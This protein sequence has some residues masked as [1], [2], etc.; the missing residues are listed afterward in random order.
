M[1][2]HVSLTPQFV[3][4]VRDTVD[5]VAIAEDYTRLTRRG[6]RYHGLCPLHREKTPSF[7]VDGERG[8][9]YCFGCGAGGDAIKLHMLLSGDDF[10][11]A[12]ES[13]A[14]RFGVPLPPPTAVRRGGGEAE[15]DLEAVLEAAAEWFGA[16]LEAHPEPRAYLER[17]AIPPEVSQRFGVGYAPPGWEGL[18]GALRSRFA[19]ADLEAAGLVAPSERHPGQHYDR[20]RN[21]LI[22]PIRNASARL[23]G[24][25]GRALGDEPAKYLNTRETERF[26]KGTLLYGLDQAKR[27]LRE[28]GRGFLVE[29]Y[30]DVLGA[31]AAGVEGAVASMGTSLTAEQARLLARYV[32]E[33]V[34]GYDGDRAGEEAFRR[35]LGILLAAGCGV[36]R[37]RLPE[38]S[39]PD[40]FRLDHGAE[41]LRRLVDTAPD[42]VEH[43][44]LRLVPPAASRDPREQARLSEPVVELLR[45]IPDAILRYAYGRRAAERLGVPFELLAPRLGRGDGPRAAP[46]PPAAAGPGRTPG[47]DL[48]HAALRVLLLAVDGAGGE[49]LPAGD[50]L[51]PPEV[52]WDADC[53]ALYAGLCEQAGDG[54]ATLA[55][56]R[57]RLEAAGSTLDLMARLLI[58]G[59]D[60]FGDGS[61]AQG[62]RAPR[63]REFLEQL[64]DRWHEQRSRELMQ[65]IHEAQRAGDLP[66]LERLVEEKTALSRQ[67]HGL[68]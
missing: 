23:V 37:A 65:Q 29:G 22:F 57:A 66:R 18:L 11:A 14:R 2:S 31:V 39:D 10:P 44:L 15:R 9:F 3:Q 68:A 35:A 52:F 67:V 62:S 25:G 53:R 20:F 43:E 50:E 59:P 58:E 34:V 8:L 33:V 28:S 41:A 46:S 32:D 24:F 21:R 27:A 38:G 7:T 30:F 36:R 16:Q 1:L 42:G 48:E 12:M 6:G 5:A 19:V 26:A 63:L 45:P 56:V 17:R 61:G 51:P 54:G 4:A 60:A 55:A 40:S 64:R 49:G 47:R 13:L